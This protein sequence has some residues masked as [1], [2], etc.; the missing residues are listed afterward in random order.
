MCIR[1]QPSRLRSPKGATPLELPS[2]KCTRRLASAQSRSRTK[3]SG[4]TSSTPPAASG[5]RATIGTLARAS[6]KTAPPSAISTG[7]GNSAARWTS[8]RRRSAWSGR[9][10]ASMT[11]ATCGT[12]C[13]GRAAA[14]SDKLFRVRQ[15]VQD[16]GKERRGPHDRTSSQGA[17]RL[18][19]ARAPVHRGRPAQGQE[20]RARLH[21][22]QPESRRVQAPATRAPV[23]RQ[24]VTVA[25][26]EI[27]L[28]DLNYTLTV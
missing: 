19:E 18:D 17:R 15:T 6:A 12:G 24:G 23:V 5:A 4:D 10:T 14:D 22:Q 16:D 26:P 28:L 27:I 13:R 8:S 1:D 2:P 21:H 20:D 25:R 7:D 9:G 3:T 11:R